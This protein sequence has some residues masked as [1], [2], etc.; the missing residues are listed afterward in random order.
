MSGT[1]QGPGAQI[2]QRRGDMIHV[3]SYTSVFLA[4]TCQNVCQSNLALGWLV[5][6]AAISMSL[7]FGYIPQNRI[8]VEDTVKMHKHESIYFICEPFM[9]RTR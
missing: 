3:I 8:L 5:W 2:P 1:H 7:Y 6:F 4:M 9:S